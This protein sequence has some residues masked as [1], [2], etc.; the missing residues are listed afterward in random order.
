MAGRRFRK[1][2]KETYSAPFKAEGSAEPLIT[3]AGLSNS[4]MQ[5][6]TTFEEYQ[7]QRYEAASTLF[8]PHQLSAFTQEFKRIATDMINKV[9]SKTDAPPKDTTKEQV[10]FV[11]GVI[12]DF[13]PIHDFGHALTKPDS[14]Y[15][16]SATVNVEFQSGNPRNNVRLESSFLTVDL[17]QGSTWK[18]VATDANP[19]TKFRWKSTT[20]TLGAESHVFIEWAIPSDAENGT[21]RICHSGDRKSVTSGLKVVPYTGC[22]DSFRV[23]GTPPP[24]PAPA[25]PVCA[26]NS[27]TIWPISGCNVACGASCGGKCCCIAGEGACGSKQDGV[28]V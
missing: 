22:S 20:I 3:I 4:Y 21:Y 18:T 28:F 8:G 15:P 19:E 7:G 2:L 17:K 24:T 27:P 5:Y 6:M 12:V 13:S 26:C 10:S 9:D 23:G 1:A 16:T 25:C 11:P 14:W